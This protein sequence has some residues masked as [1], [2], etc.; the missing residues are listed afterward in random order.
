MKPTVVELGQIYKAKNPGEVDHISDEEVGYY[1]QSLSPYYASKV[2][3]VTPTNSTTSLQVVHNKSI[4]NRPLVTEDIIPLSFNDQT[5]TRLQ[6]LQNSLK[7]NQWFFRNLRQQYNS[8]KDIAYNEIITKH[9]L[10]IIEQGARVEKAAMERH[11]EM[12]KYQRFI[13]EN[14]YALLE[15]QAATQ[16]LQDAT[17]NGLTLENYQKLKKKEF[18][19]HLKRIKKAQEYAHLERM[20]MIKRSSA[21]E[22]DLSD[23]RVNEYRQKSQIDLED[24]S[25]TAYEKLKFKIVG[26]RLSSHQEVALLQ[27]M[28]DEQYV[29]IA[30]IWESEIIPEAA[31]PDMVA[32][33]K[34]IIEKYMD[35]QNEAQK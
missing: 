31:K 30:E 20:E 6:N 8:D 16:L 17:Y 25:K 7:P 26:E 24:E 11:T 5:Q 33:R 29:K 22:Q 19:A 14:E 21:N 35:R 2:I 4:E 32:S 12:V 18:K 23:I 10:V 9:A 15:L 28:I 3:D 27:D 1:V 34:R 13:K